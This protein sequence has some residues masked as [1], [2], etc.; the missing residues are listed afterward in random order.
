GHH[1]GEEPVGLLEIRVG[2]VLAVPDPVVGQRGDLM[3]RLVAAADIALRR[4]LVDVV[5]EVDDQVEVLVGHMP[6]R[7]EIAR[8]VILTGCERESEFRFHRRERRSR[9]RTPDRTDITSYPKTIKIF[10]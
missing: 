3:R 10:S 4:A 5:A 1:P 9:S 8:R 6:V 7:G 2:P